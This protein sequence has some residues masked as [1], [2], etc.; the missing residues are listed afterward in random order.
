MKKTVLFILGFLFVVSL[1]FGQSVVINE[2]SQGSDGAKEWVELLVVENNIDIRGWELGDNDDGI[3]HPIVE[4]TTH[5]DWSNLA[6][7]TIVVIYNGGDIDATITAAGGEDTDFSDNVVII[8]ESNT[9]Y[10]TDIGGWP[11]SG[12]FGNTDR[13][14]C[15]AIQNATDV[16]I[17]DMAITHPTATVDSPISGN[18]KYFTEDSLVEL[19]IDSN[20]TEAASSNGTPGLGNGGNNTTW[21]EGLLP[22]TLTSFTA[23]FINDNLTILWTTQSETSNQGWNIYR[24]ESENALEND[25]TIQINNT[26]LIEGAGNSSQPIDYSFQDEYTVVENNTYWYWLE[27]VS[28]SNDT[29]IYGPI[30]LT[31]PEGAVIPEL[32]T[33]TFMNSN[34]PNP[35]NPETIIEFSIK[36]NETGSLTIHNTKG[37]VLETHNYETGEHELTWDATQYG[38]GIYFYKLETQS[39]TETKKMIMLK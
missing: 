23:Q 15:A 25:E 1:A 38:S 4:F 14:D 24:G 39:Y 32:P 21:I 7:G 26:G 29:E 28:Y 3:W 19:V 22:V 8:P 5:L 13:D 17:H 37:Q 35:F 33:L 10:L 11:G 18:V 6:Q 16:I 31:I 30:S 34:Y 36:E 12:V 27:S 9:T 2:M 20:W